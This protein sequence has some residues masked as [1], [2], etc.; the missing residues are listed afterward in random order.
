[1][2]IMKMV[3]VPVVQEVDVAVMLNF[4][5]PAG[6]MVHMDVGSM[7]GVIHRGLL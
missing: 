6:V 3:H 4:R 2:V 7:R 5:M 1:M